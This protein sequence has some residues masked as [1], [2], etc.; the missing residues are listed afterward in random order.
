[1]SDR[2][3]RRQFLTAAT[4]GGAGVVSAAALGGALAD[5]AVVQAADL[6]VDQ[7]DPEFL[8]GKVV[9]VEGSS[10]V[11]LSGDLLLRR[12]LAG[13]GTEV[14]KIR[15][16]TIEEIRADDWVYARGTPMPDGAFAAHSIWVNIVNV[17]FQ[18]VGVEQ[19]RF[20]LD[21]GGERWVGH[22]QPDTVAR[23]SLRAP[24]RD[25]SGVTVGSHVQVVGAWRPDTNE[26][27][28]STVFA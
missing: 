26:I 1:M 2:I 23:H 24:T 25:L 9:S 5:V 19:D 18:V 20:H 28:V 10:L 12:V 17:H 6:A 3:H 27:D 16:T 14:W 13:S 4:L 8:E 22:V 11:V 15:D 7:P 21:H